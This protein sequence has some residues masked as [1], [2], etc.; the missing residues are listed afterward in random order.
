MK[1]VVLDGHTLNPGDNPWN[2]V[3][4]AVGPDSEFVVYPRTEPEDV[5]ARSQGAEILL[6]NKTVITK[7]HLETLPDVKLICVLATGVNAVDLEASKALGICVCNVPEY[8]TLSVAQFVFAQI[9]H[10]SHQVAH[11]DQ[12][13]REGKWEE[14]GEFSFWDTPQ[15]ELA[16]RTLGIIGFGRI[17]QAVANLGRAFG[18]NVIA[19]SP[20]MTESNA[21]AECVSLNALLEQSDIVSLHCPLTSDNQHL[22]RQE[23]L[24]RMRKGSLLINTARGGLVCEPDLREALVSRHLG[25]AALDVSEKEPMPLDSPLLDA[26][27]VLLTPHMA[28][29]SVHARRRLMETTGENITAWLEGKPKSRVA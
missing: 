17:G 14:C 8:G 26:P 13:I 28:W 6:T 15:I 7:A 19:Y 2:P 25:G 4:E 1:V 22:I 29:G 24:D 9:L 21:L 12:R 27:N 16:G 10:L 20:R 18:L 23:T 11:H 5:V 3:S